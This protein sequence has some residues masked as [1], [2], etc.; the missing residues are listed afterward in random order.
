M[1][2]FSPTLVVNNKLIAISYTTDA[3]REVIHPWVGERDGHQVVYCMKKHITIDEF[4]KRLASGEDG[5]RVRGMRLSNGL[6]TTIS[7]VRKDRVTVSPE[8]TRILLA[9]RGK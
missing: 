9:L 8:L 7:F 1:E 4:F 5:L 2:T 6:N 3:P